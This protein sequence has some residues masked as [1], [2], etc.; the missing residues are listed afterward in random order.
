MARSGPSKV[1]FL[2]RYGAAVLLVTA[3]ALGGGSPVEAGPPPAPPWTTFT[4]SATSGDY[5]G[6]LSVFGEGFPANQDQYLQLF[7]CTPSPQIDFGNCEDPSRVN[8]NNG[9]EIVGAHGVVEGPLE[10]GYF[11]LPSTDQEWNCQ[12]NPCIIR[13]AICNNGLSPC[14]SIIPIV[15]FATSFDGRGFLTLVPGQGPYTEDQSVR[16]TGGG[17]PVGIDLQLQQCVVRGSTVSADECSSLNT[18]FT[19]T[20][21]N[22]EMSLVHRVVRKLP[23]GDAPV[24]CVDEPCALF[25]TDPELSR[26]LASVPLPFE[27]APPAP[28]SDPISAEP[29]FTG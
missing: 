7:Q 8:P 29:R 21:E 2:K 16:V 1:T 11:Y 6:S 17:L 27:E 14:S 25:V 26:V 9:Y 19:A 22:G 28:V 4:V 15:A 13:P 20:G 10:L 23:A 24:D 18:G 12:T 3:L 5:P